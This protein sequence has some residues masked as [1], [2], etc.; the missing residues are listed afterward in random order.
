MEE[1]RVCIPQCVFREGGIIYIG[2]SWVV[3]CINDRSY[4]YLYVHEIR[5]GK[6]VY[7]PEKDT[8]VITYGPWLHEM[9]E[10]CYEFN[11]GVINPYIVLDL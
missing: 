5:P 2:G 6:R 11:N 8:G 1:Y 7:V 10:K 3:I 4:K 9:R